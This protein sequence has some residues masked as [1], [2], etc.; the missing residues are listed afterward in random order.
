MEQE[1]A[2]S[3]DIPDKPDASEHN[4]KKELMQ[5]NKDLIKKI[6]KL[7]ENFENEDIKQQPAKKNTGQ[8]ASTSTV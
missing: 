7:L 1:L 3:R 8:Q 5:G 4:P 2:K 6:K